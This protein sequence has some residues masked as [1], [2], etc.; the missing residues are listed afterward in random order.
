MEVPGGVPYI[1]RY[2]KE[3]MNVQPSNA[4]AS[5]RHATAFVARSIENM[6]GSTSFTAFRD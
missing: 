2:I 3:K 6:M 4:A 5:P 1:L